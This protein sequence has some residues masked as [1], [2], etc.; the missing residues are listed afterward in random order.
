VEQGVGEVIESALAAVTPVA[1]A[2]RAVVVLP[3]RIDVLALAPGT[4]KGALFPSQRVDIDL[5]LLD[6]EEVVDIREHGHG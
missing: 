3:P 2:S 1:F 4:L 5:A 6:I